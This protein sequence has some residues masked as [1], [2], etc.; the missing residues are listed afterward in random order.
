M[1]GEEWEGTVPDAAKKN[2]EGFRDLEVV[3]KFVLDNW[4]KAGEVGWERQ[5]KRAME[6][7]KAKA[8]KKRKVGEE[9]KE[10]VS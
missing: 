3:R 2:E 8:E 4:K 7:M 10:S 9:R 6:G 1:E 5:Q